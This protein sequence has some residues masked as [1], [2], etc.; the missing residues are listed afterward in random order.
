MGDRRYFFVE[1]CLPINF[2]QL[3]HTNLLEFPL[4]CN[5]RKFLSNRWHVHE[6]YGRDWKKFME[7]G[8]EVSSKL[9]DQLD[10]RTQAKCRKVLSCVVRLYRRDT[11]NRFWVQNDGMSW[12]SKNIFPRNTITSIFRNL[13]WNRSQSLRQTVE[14]GAWSF[15][16]VV[17]FNRLSTFGTYSLNL[18]IYVAKIE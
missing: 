17:S 3:R 5:S 6:S 14:N 10:V 18:F 12:K 13:T 11:K 4:F 2:L 15:V 8:N 9:Q 1:I 7:Y 16:Q